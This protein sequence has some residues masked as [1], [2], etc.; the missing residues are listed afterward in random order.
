MILTLLR[1]ASTLGTGSWFQ[2]FQGFQSAV[3]LQDTLMN[4]LLLQHYVKYKQ[5]SFKAMT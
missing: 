2:E 5:L 1:Q 4:V 3:I